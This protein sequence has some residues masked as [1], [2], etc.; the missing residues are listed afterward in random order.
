MTPNLKKRKKKDKEDKNS[1]NYNKR[2]KT[3]LPAK[4]VHVCLCWREGRGREQ[5]NETCRV[6]YSSYQL[7]DVNNSSQLTRSVAVVVVGLAE[8]VAMA[9]TW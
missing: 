3:T 7:S 4:C 2:L 6:N 1:R 5:E 8:G 9:W